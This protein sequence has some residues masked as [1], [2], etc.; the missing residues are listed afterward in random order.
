MPAISKLMC[1][2]G[3][4]A[5]CGCRFC[6]LKGVYSEKYRHVYFPC[7]MPRSSDISDFNPE[8]LPIH[9]EHDFFSD[10]DKIMN[11]TNKTRRKSCIKETG[12]INF[13]LI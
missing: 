10:V 7:S 1:M 13:Y 12:I 9:S 11:E 5:Y 2:S 3:H 4:N 8:D 6:H